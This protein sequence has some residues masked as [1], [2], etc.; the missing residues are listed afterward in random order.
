MKVCIP[1]KNTDVTNSRAILKNINN[2]FLTTWDTYKIGKEKYAS[3]IS[4]LMKAGLVA[5]DENKEKP[6]NEYTIADID[7][8]KEWDKQDFYKPIKEFVI[9]LLKMACEIVPL[10]VK[11]L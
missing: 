7:K 3:L 5:D 4:V 2:N 10:V 11:N 9:P 1:R 6:T 8:Y